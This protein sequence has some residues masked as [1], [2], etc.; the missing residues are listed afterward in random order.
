MLFD[1]LQKQ[2]MTKRLWQYVYC[3][4]GAVIITFMAFSLTLIG[5]DQYLVAHI[6]EFK[7]GLV[8]GLIHIK[9]D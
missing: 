5:N 4:L 8:M 1:N 9:D 2:G 6:L 3:L 7:D